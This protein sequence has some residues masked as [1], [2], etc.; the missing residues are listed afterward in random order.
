M[1]Q[2]VAFLGP[3]VRGEFRPA[4]RVIDGAAGVIGLKA[5]R[6]APGIDV[7]E[8]CFR[9]ILAVGLVCLLHTV[10][11]LSALALKCDMVIGG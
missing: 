7:K 8:G 3:G 4:L 11:K 1:R 5:V 10:I 9:E 2:S 6:L